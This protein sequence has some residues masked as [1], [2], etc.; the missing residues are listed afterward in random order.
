[1][2]TYLAFDLGAGSGRALTGTLNGLKLEL[3][4]IHRFHNGPVKILNHYHWGIVRLFEQ[5]LASLHKCRD[6]NLK[7]L[8]INT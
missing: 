7:K 5:M 2:Q 6:L 4:E 3:N 8:A 1:M